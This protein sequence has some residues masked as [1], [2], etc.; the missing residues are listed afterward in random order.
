M[1]MLC[2]DFVD[3]DAKIGW[4]CVWWEMIE[5]GMV[6]QKLTNNGVREVMSKKTEIGFVRGAELLLLLGG[7]EYA[8][9][10]QHVQVGWGGAIIV[11][12]T[13]SMVTS[14][15]ECMVGDIGTG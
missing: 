3:K 4:N 9:V 8:G 6:G 15:D 12:A 7:E 2:V 5:G 14:R 11:R 10:S 1:K 13:R